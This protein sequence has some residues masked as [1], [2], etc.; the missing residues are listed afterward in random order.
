VPPLVVPPLSPPLHPAM[1]K[2][3]MSVKE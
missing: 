3:R 1:I 2:A